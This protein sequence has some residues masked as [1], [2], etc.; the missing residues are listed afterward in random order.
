MKAENLNFH[1]RTLRSRLQSLPSLSGTKLVEWPCRTNLIL[2]HF[3]SLFSLLV[4]VCLSLCVPCVYI[5]L[6]VFHVSVCA[7]HSPSLIPHLYHWIPV[8]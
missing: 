5:S 8:S 2:Y 3:P 6:S 4:S 7:S 1:K